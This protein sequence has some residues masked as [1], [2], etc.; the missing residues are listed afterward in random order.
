MK[1]KNKIYLKLAESLAN[2][3]APMVE[4]ALFDKENQLIAIYNR[5]THEAT[6]IC[7][8]HQMR[9]LI[10]N[11]NQ[12][13]KTMQIPLD[14][15][16]CLRLIV[17][18]TIFESLKTLL[19]QYLTKEIKN[20]NITHWQQTVDNF[21]DTFLAERNTTLSAL[22]SQT[23]RALVLAIQENKLLCYQDATNYLANKLDVS[24][25][26]IYN[27]LKQANQLKS[28]QIHQVDAFTDE[29]FSGN[30]AGVVLEADHLDDVMMK[31]IAR[32][33]NLSETSFMSSSRKSD[34]KLRYFTPSGSEVKF[35]GH[36]TVAA[37]YMLAHN[38]MFGINKPGSYQLSIEA[39]VGEIPAVVTI[40]PDQA[41]T[42]QFQTPKV[43]LDASDFT[44]QQIADALGIPL[45]VINLK[46]PVMFEKTN[47]DLY[48]TISSLQRLGELQVDTKSAKQFAET[49]HIVAYVLL[50]NETVCEKSHLHM[51]CYAPA[52]GIPEDPFTGSVLGGLAAYVTQ[53]NMLEKH[54]QTIR[55]EQGH[56]M[57]RP[58]HV[59]I[60]LNPTPNASPT[61]IAK[62]RHFFSTEISL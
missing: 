25:A 26:T 51:R 33:M 58:G 41:I 34:F 57:S 24:R 43:E 17:E 14:E 7:E 5:L 44:H 55:V 42:I 52:V 39:E 27:Y 59:D 37:L 53:N 31:K 11:K 19:Q 32:E 61:V 1:E 49:H 29:P 15:G 35:C 54:H 16:Y 22:T 3:F 12:S 20:E 21:I 62:A 47:Q 2:L 45:E 10:I 50:T 48:I 23:K 8:P 4:V 36:S 9:K 56:F 60:K 18:T 13:A 6:N 28:L 38:K 30:P 40:E 46:Q